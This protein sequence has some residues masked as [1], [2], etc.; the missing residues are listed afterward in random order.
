MRSISL[1]ENK[2][3]KQPAPTVPTE[4]PPVDRHPADRLHLPIVGIFIL[5]LIYFMVW[6]GQFL[7][8]VLAAVL[9]YFVLNRPRRKLQ[10]LGIPPVVSAALFTVILGALIGFLLVQLSSPTAD[11]IEDLPSLLERISDTLASSGKTMQAI[12]DATVAAEDILDQADTGT[13]EVEVVSN[14]GLASTLV[15][16]AP[17]FL[18]RIMMTLILLFFL[19][20]SGD[21]FL[22]KVVQ[23]FEQFNDKRQAVAVL[24]SIEERLGYYLGGITFINLGLGVAI[25]IAMWFWG[26]PV[27]ALLGMMAFGLNFIPFLGGL[28]GALVA[29]AVAFVTFQD[30][31]P[32]L[33]VLI[34]YLGLTSVE[35]QLVTPYLISRRMRLN[36]T[37][38]FL[39]VAFFAWIW[40][41][42]GMVVAVPIL[43]V[44]KIVCDETG[45]MQTV[46]RFLG[47]ID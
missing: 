3:S 33:G 6:A 4:G 10:R 26:L 31:W 24:H 38:V 18:G 42:I 25:A 20:S 17:M 13:L 5:L 39:S 9:G 32:A 40:S 16:F 14:T 1:P 41:V 37:V 22:T 8:P 19:V 23:S 29:A 30:P 35:G 21:L 15:S 45:R 27:A 7:V 36:T 44:I 12:S 28:L 43:I 46:S 11:F 34:T 47:D 2:P